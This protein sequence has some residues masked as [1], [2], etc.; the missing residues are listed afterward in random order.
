MTARS[1][2]LL[3]LLL[4]QPSLPFALRFRS[5]YNMTVLDDLVY[6]TA[7]VSKQCECRER[8]WEDTLCVGVT[9]M[10]SNHRTG[11]SCLFTNHTSI[12]PN[13]EGL[14]TTLPG[15]ASFLKS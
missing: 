5:V 10:P 11:Y 6:S 7:S 1:G 13:Y 3:L 2:L 8:C 15:A 9:V 12:L 14:I 4:H